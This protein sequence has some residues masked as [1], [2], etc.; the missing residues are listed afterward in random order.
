ML[1]QD[2]SKVLKSLELL[3]LQNLRSHSSSI[4]TCQCRSLQEGGR[5]LKELLVEG[6]EFALVAGM[7]NRAGRT[8]ISQEKD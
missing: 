6:F 8:P 1:R 2:L 5:E 3:S 4:L 7:A